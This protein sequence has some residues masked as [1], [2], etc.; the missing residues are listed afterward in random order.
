MSLKGGLKC[1]QCDLG[2]AY[3]ANYDFQLLK[4]VYRTSLVRIGKSLMGKKFKSFQKYLAELCPN[5]TSLVGLNGR[6]R[7]MNTLFWL[8]ISSQCSDWVEL[9]A[10]QHPDCI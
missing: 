5:L 3:A 6:L 4:W 1:S 7:Y 2:W 9:V 8:L 10:S